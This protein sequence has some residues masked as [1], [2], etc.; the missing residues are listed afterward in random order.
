MVKEIKRDYYLEQ[1]NIYH[2]EISL[3]KTYLSPCKI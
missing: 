2:L 3:I 1:L